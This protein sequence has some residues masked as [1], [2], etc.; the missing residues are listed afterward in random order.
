METL[1][2]TLLGDRQQKKLWYEK[3]LAAIHR[4]EAEEKI[5]SQTY[6][7]QKQRKAKLKQKLLKSFES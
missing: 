4:Y 1:S 7:F 3:Y 6:L 2:S 5:S